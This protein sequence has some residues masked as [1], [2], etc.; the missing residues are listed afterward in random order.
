MPDSTQQNTSATG[1]NKRP[2]NLDYE[3]TNPSGPML[4]TSRKEAVSSN[5]NRV[6]EKEKSN[7]RNGQND[8]FLKMEARL[9][10]LQGLLESL[11]NALAQETKTLASK[12]LSRKIEVLHCE[13]RVKYHD[14][15]SSFLPGSIRGF[16]FNLTCKAEYEDTKEFKEQ[17]TIANRLVMNTKQALRDC[18][19]KV[20]ELEDEGSKNKL[21]NMVVKG[22][23]ALFI[24]WVN[25]LKFAHPDLAPPYNND[26]GAEVMLA[27]YFNCA[28]DE[29]FTY[30]HIEK[31]AFVKQHIDPRAERI[32]Y[33]SDAKT[34]DEQYEVAD[35]FKE[36]V[37]NKCF[38]SIKQLTIDLFATYTQK[39][40][41]QEAE[42]RTEALIKNRD[43]ASITA[44]TAE[45]IEKEQNVKPKHLVSLIEECAEEAITNAQ[46]KK[47][48]KSKKEKKNL[49]K[50]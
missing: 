6:L 24:C 30:L 5:P 22:F 35:K 41:E 23:N 19:V 20:M 7:D 27:H 8:A 13:R 34:T 3:K 18:M 46:K 9:A 40:N 29:F 39:L 15:N 17:L 36:L 47:N 32:T 49:P 38:P 28:E 26:E 45:A 50:A 4:K 11:P 43:T 42:K 31:R 37:C 2:R 44:A 1:P 25:Y 48:K 33:L 21:H 12:L 14:D 10:P 16:K